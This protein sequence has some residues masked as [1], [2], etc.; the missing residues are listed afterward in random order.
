M[1]NEPSL[2]GAW[3][4]RG[5][6]GTRVEIKTPEITV[7]WRN[8][9]VLETK[10]KAENRDGETVLKLKNDG[11][12]YPNTYSD[13]AKVTELV[14]SDG[15]LIFKKLFV[16]SGE[17][18]EILEKTENSRYGNY[19]IADKEILH[20]LKGEWVT[21]DGYFHLNFCGDVLNV[22]GNKI[23]I[24]ALKSN[25]GYPNR[26]IYKIVDADP[27]NYGIHD[28]SEMTYDNGRL[29]AVIPVC[30]APSIIVEFIKNK[31]KSNR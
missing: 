26:N 11:L 25:S 27:S 21:E 20:L 19:T 15:K 16:I 31:N 5:V 14:Y 1:K 13:F 22:N 2:D 9:P 3:E 23:S 10:F 7:L 8:T 29:V 6:I 30:D 24:H 18:C 4:E 12:R 28:F 17:D